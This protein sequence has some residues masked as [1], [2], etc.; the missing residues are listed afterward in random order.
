VIAF[1][2][3]VLVAVWLLGTS[4]LSLAQESQG[5]EPAPEAQPAEPEAS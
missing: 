5:E 4:T 1:R 3:L 2:L